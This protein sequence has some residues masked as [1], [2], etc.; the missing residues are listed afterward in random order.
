MDVEKT[1]TIAAPV[2]KVWETLLDP[3]IMARCVPGTQSVDVLSDVEYSA[4]I[5][6]KIS[7]ISAKFKVNTTILETKAPTYLRCEGTGEDKSVASSMKQ[8]TELFLTD[9]GDGSTEINV[10]A[11]AQVFGKLGSFGLSIMK[12]KIDRMWR[13]FGDNLTEKI[14]APEGVSD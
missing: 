13:E 3:E 12:T 1:M 10:K 7:F 5:K 9:L 11:Q 6:V 8:E 2:D 14:A 4:V